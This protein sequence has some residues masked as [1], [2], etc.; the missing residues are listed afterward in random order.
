MGGFDHYTVLA[1]LFAAVVHLSDILPSNRDWYQAPYVLVS[2]ESTN[3]SWLKCQAECWDSW[4]FINLQEDL[5]HVGMQ[6]VPL[7]ISWR[8]FVRSGSEV[9][10]RSK[11]REMYNKS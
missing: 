3:V 8:A 10:L 7:F 5:W 11:I 4:S 2:P 6:L 9:S 1:F